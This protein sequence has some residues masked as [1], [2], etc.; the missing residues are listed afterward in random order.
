LPA[1]EPPARHW[2]T[3]KRKNTSLTLSLSLT[4]SALRV[5]IPNYP[6]FRSDSRR[7]PVLFCAVFP[8]PQKKKKKKKT[9]KIIRKRLSSPPVNHVRRAVRVG[10]HFAEYVGIVFYLFIYFFFFSHHSDQNQTI[11]IPIQFLSYQF[12]SFHLFFFLFLHFILIVPTADIAEHDRF[13][14]GALTTHRLRRQSAAARSTPLV[15]QCVCTC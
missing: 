2:K 11:S 5:R 1:A 12:C 10:A 9:K 4:I 6:Q 3:L 8:R 7:Q 15:L 14:S 13:V